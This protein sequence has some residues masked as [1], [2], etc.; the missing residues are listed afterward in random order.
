MLYAFGIFAWYWLG[1]RHI[2][3]VSFWCFE[4]DK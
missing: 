2:I 3:I 4:G 1:Y